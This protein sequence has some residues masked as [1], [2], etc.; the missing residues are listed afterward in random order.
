MD[1]Y[2]VHAAYTDHMVVAMQI[3]EKIAIHLGS[4]VNKSRSQLGF[5]RTS[6]T[7][8][9]SMTMPSGPTRNIAQA[10]SGA[11][12]TSLAFRAKRKTSALHAI[13]AHIQCHQ[14][15]CFPNTISLRRP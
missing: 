7:T 14:T 13:K 15:N 10:S 9:T 12:A 6:R 3:K 1:L 11:D 8:R 2:A 5:L 4:P